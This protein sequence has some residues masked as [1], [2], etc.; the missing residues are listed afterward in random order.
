MDPEHSAH[1]STNL[2][3]C[4]SRALGLM[5]VLPGKVKCL[6]ELVTRGGEH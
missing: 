5:K 1:L 4:P 3:L 2:G 6:A